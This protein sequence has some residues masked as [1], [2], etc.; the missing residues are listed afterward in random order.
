[1][2]EPRFLSTSDVLWLHGRS[3]ELFGGSDGLRDRGLFEAAVHQAQNVYWYGCGD[4]WDIA[5]AYA[6]HIAEAQAF[7]DGNKRTAVA[8][9]LTFLAINGHESGDDLAPALYPAMIAVAKRELDR[10]GLA[11]LLKQLHS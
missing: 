6:F 5:A 9:E 3:I 10:K 11:E 7:I 2:N 1:M 8:A 4:L